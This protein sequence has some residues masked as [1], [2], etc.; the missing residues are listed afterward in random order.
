MI[1]PAAFLASGWVEIRIQ[2][3]I[4][5]KTQDIGNIVPGKEGPNGM[6]A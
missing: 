3:I 2:N 5:Y 1:W 6:L 4:W